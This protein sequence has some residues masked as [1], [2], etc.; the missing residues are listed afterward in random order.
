M[1]AMMRF[2][3]IRSLSSR[4]FARGVAAAQPLHRG[5]L[6]VVYLEVGFTFSSAVERRG[7]W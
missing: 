3:L 5:Q 1:K 4:E 2:R 6:R 7:I